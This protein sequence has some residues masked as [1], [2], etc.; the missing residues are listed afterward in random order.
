[1]KPLPRAATTTAAIRALTSLDDF[2]AYV[3]PQ[4]ARGDPSRCAGRDLSK[5]VQGRQLAAG[6]AV[7]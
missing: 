5:R 7:R 2:A 1:M 4:T 6:Y 3:T